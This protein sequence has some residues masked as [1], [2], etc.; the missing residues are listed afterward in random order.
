MTPNLKFTEHQKT[1]KCELPQQRH[2]DIGWKGVNELLSSLQT[3]SEFWSYYSGFEVS[4]DF[5][6]LIGD[7]MFI[8]PC[9]ILMTE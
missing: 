5:A 1:L 4:Q 8:G 9:I 2:N 7:L 6:E 3:L